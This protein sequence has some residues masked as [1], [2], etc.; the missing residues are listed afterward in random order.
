MNA[1]ID[2]I[3]AH[4]EAIA[5][6]N[7]TPGQGTTRLTYSP[8]YRAGCDYLL[9][10]ADRLGLAG[11]LDAVGNV[12]IRL[13]GAEPGAP[14]VVVGSH[15]DTVRH[16]GDFDGV[17]GVA[18]GLEAL[19]AL[20][21]AG[22]RPVRPVELISFIEEE[23]ATFACPLAGSKAVAG[24]LEIADLQRVRDESGRSL[25]ERAQEFGAD[26]D[27]LVADRLGPASVAAMLEL[28]I[29]QS[30]LLESE[31]IPVGIVDS[32][33]GSETYR[34]HL[35]GVAN[36]AGTTP[37]HQR[38]DALAAAAEIVLAVERAAKES[39]RSTTVATVGRIHCHPNAGNAIPGRVDLSLDV[40]DIDG[41]AI[42]AAVA[43]ILAAAEA[44]ADARAIGFHAEHTG[45]SAPRPFSRPLADRLAT[46]A[47]AADIPYRRMHSGALHDAAT[48]SGITDA[49]MLFV[50]S[51][52]GISHSP[53]EWT[54]WADV[55]P[56][57]NLL[58]AALHDLADN[59]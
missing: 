40:R 33:A 27:A 1:D 22:I 52:G 51:R 3:R 16:G 55:E 59:P 24:R 32:I 19:E 9:G 42:D 30:P 25:Y 29:E 58:L 28:H 17:L 54:D 35:E 56:G 47:E 36:H 48:L 39:D 23:A 44:I 2:R 6:F 37:M 15:I 53:E 7:A 57:A 38:H 5:R 14:A 46:L 20:V 34:L 8:E 13:P 50:P 41:A 31:G 43:G 11:R 10:A 18:C 21:H 12:R 26:P 4:V 45:G 49:A